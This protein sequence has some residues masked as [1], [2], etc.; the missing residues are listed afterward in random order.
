M[1]QHL[2][3]RIFLSPYVQTTYGEGGGPPFRNPLS[4]KDLRQSL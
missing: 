2:H 3:G 4:R 1:A